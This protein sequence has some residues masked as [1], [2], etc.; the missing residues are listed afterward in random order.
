VIVYISPPF[1][2]ESNATTTRVA[3]GLAA[4]D[5]IIRECPN[6]LKESV[7]GHGRRRK[8]A[9]DEQHDWIEIRRGYCNECLKTITFLP[10]FSLPYTHYSLMAR[11]QCLKGYFVEGRSLELATPLLKDADRVPAG[12]TISGWFRKLESKERMESLQ[13]QQAEWAVVPDTS[14]SFVP[15]GRRSSFPFLRKMVSAISDRV[16]GPERLRS[17]DLVLT[18]PTVAHF[19]HSLVPL[20]C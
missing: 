18:W 9:H 17:G 8:Q 20:R 10:W 16:A 3:A 11:S 7:I 14:C 2:T 15:S 12:S 19:L 6:C 4:S 13:Q 5:G 1:V